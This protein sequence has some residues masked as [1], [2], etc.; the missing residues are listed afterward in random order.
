MRHFEVVGDED[1]D[2]EGDV[3]GDVMGYDGPM[4]GYEGG[5]EVVGHDDYGY[6]IVVGRGRPRR[7]RPMVALSKP[8][9][10]QGQL[11]PGVIAPDQGLLPLPMGNFTF[12]AAAQTFT[13]SGQIQKPFR[14]ER[15]LVTTV[16]TGASATGRL[17]GQPFVGT[18]LA[19]LDINPIDIEQIGALNAF[20]VR[21]TMKPA[22]PGVFIRIVTSLSNALTGTDTIFASVQLLG[23]NIH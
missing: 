1:Q 4:G 3:M 6:P 9:W 7:R 10:R 5:A 11:A 19:L 18:D 2:V 16:R 14:G 15:L 17:L 20:G 8:G 21:L 23:R 12:A 22:Q 13:F